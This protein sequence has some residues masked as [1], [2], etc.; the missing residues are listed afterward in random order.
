MTK[1]ISQQSI[2]NQQNVS[3]IQYKNMQK[4]LGNHKYEL[5]ALN[6]INSNINLEATVFLVVKEK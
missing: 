1:T 3:S 2:Q 6:V 5:P 4:Y